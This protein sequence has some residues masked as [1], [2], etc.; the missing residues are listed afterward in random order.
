MSSKLFLVVLLLRSLEKYIE[1]ARRKLDGLVSDIEYVE[2][3][4]QQDIQDTESLLLIMKLHFLQ[5]RAR[6]T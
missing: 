6:Q 2:Q 5:S 1:Q 3:V 4:V